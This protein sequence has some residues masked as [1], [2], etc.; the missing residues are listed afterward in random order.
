MSPDR[1]FEFYRFGGTGGADPND[2]LMMEAAS[3]MNGSKPLAA[4]WRDRGFR[5]CA[6]VERQCNNHR[7]V[8]VRTGCA[9]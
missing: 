9:R 5:G 7:G 1:S 6:N 8:S 3:K 2:V 4:Q